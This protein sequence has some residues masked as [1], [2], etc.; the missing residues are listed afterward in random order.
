MVSGLV[1]PDNF[2]V[3]KVMGEITRR[4]ISP[5]AI[6][7]RLGDDDRVVEV[8]VE[9]ARRDSPCLTDDE[10][11]SVAA[12]A[13]RAEKHFGCPQDVEWALDT[14]LP[15]GANV[16]LLQSRPE[17]VWSRK[18]REA[19]PAAR[20]TFTSIVRTLVNPHHGRPDVGS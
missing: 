18:R 1:T 12:M 6:E 20:D 2:L 4:T 8:A 14:Q 19:D 10:V 15:D 5:K 3:D 11:K 13:R 17:T 9:P 7:H 16:L